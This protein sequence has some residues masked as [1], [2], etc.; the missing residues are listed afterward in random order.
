[1]SIFHKLETNNRVFFKWMPALFFTIILFV[2]P[3]MVFGQSRYVTTSG[4]NTTD[5]SDPS[6]PCLTI[7]YAMGQAIAGDHI[8]VAAGTYNENVQ[9][10]KS[11]QLLGTDA[12]VNGSTGHLGTFWISN[13]INDVTIDGFTLVGYDNANGS[14]EHAAL[15]IQG[16]N[17]NVTIT[18]NIITANGEAGLLT[19][20]ASSNNL[21][22]SGN[23]FN[24]QTFTG[25]HPGECGFST[26]F[27][28]P[29]TN[30]PRQLVVIQPGHTNLV[31][32]NNILSG[33][34]G[35]L[36]AG[37]P[38]P[39]DVI[40]QGNFLVT[41]DGTDS[42]ISGN[43]FNGQTSRFGSLLRVR[44]TGNS[45]F[46]NHF[47]AANLVGTAYFLYYSATALVGGVP[48]DA[49]GVL[50]SNTWSP[51]PTY[52][53]DLAGNTS[54]LFCDEPVL[55]ASLTIDGDTYASSTTGN[56]GNNEV[57]EIDVCSVSEEI[58]F[59]DFRDVS[60][61][62]FPD[63]K[64]YQIVEADNISAPFC[65]YCVGTFDVFNPYSATISLID[66]TQ[67]GTL[68]LK[69]FAF[70]D[71]H[72]LGVVDLDEC[73]GD[74]LIYII[75]L[76]PPLTGVA[77]EADP[78]GDVCLGATDVQYNAVVTGGN[79]SALEYLWTA[80]NNGTGAGAGF[81][82]FSDNSIQNPTR[83]WTA[84][85]GTKSVKVVVSSEG[86][87]DVE[88]LYVFEVTQD[89]E[90]PTLENT[91]H[92]TDEDVCVGTELWAEFDPGSGGAGDC[93]DEI[94]YSV[95]GG[96]TWNPYVSGNT[97]I[98]GSETVIIE[99]RRACDGLGCDGAGSVFAEMIR[100]N[101]LP[102]PVV[103][104]D[105]IDVDVCLNTDVNIVANISGGSAPY[106][107]TWTGTGEVYLN[108]VALL[109]PIFNSNVFGTYTL[110]INVTD[111]N[112]CSASD[113]IVINVR[114]VVSPTIVCPSDIRID[115]PIGECETVVNFEV[116][117]DD[118]CS[119]VVYHYVAGS[120]ESGDIFPIGV[121]EVSVYA[122]DVAG[123]ISETCSFTVT[124]VDYIN[125]NLGCKPINFSLD[126]DCTGELTP[127]EVLVGWETG[128]LPDL[129]CPGSFTIDVISP[130]GVSLGN[131]LDGEYIG[132]TL[133]YIITHVSGFRCWNTVLV[134]DKMSPTIACRDT[135]VHCLTDLTKFDLYTIFDNCGA[136]GVKI[137]EK[138]IDLPCDA[139]Y[140]SKVERTYKAVDNYGN[141]STPCTSTIY[142]LRPSRD[143]IVAPGTLVT[144]ECSE[145]YKKDGKGF[146]HPDVAGIPTFEGRELW[147]QSNLDMLYCNA[148]I[149][150]KERV[151][152]ESGC[153]TIIQRTWTIT[154]WHCSSVVELLVA[155]Q[156]LMI[157]DTT[158][159]AIP[160]QNDQVVTTKALSCS[161]LVQLPQL[162][163]TDNCNT[164]TKVL[165]NVITDGEPNG[166]V[167]GNGGSIEL[168]VGVHTITYSALDN[169]LNQ[170]EM[171]YTITVRDLTDPVAICDQFATVSLREDGQT[172]VTAQ[173]IN[174]GSF[175][176]CGDVT[177]QIRRLT[178]P[179]GLDQ[180][181][182]WY[183]RIDFCCA[184]A[185]QS[186]MVVLLVT[187]RGG[188]TNMCMVSVNVQDKI[189]P[190]I[191]CPED[192]TIR[193]CEFTFDPSLSGANHAFGEAVIT[194]NC[195]SNLD[196]L[197]EIQ[198]NRSQCGV[199]EVI[200][201]IGVAL[202]GKTIQTCQQ[203][204]TFYNDH[205]FYI[206]ES[207]I[208]DP[209]DGVIW[210]KDYTAL[211][212]CS[213]NGLAP[214][215]LPD[216]SSFPIITEGVCDMV[217]LRYDDQVIAFTQNGACYKI[218]RTWSIIDWCQ[219]NREW[220]YVQEIKVIDNDA[221]VFV[222]LPT[223]K[224]I[225]GT[226]TCES[227]E[228]TLDANAI[229]CTPAD[230]LVWTYK[231][232]KSGV[233]FQ[234]GNGN[235]VTDIFTVGEYSI[236]FTVSD[237][238][239]NLSQTSYEFEVI[240]TKPAVPICINGLSS[241]VTMM[242]TDGDGIGDTP[243]TMLTPELFDNKSY[244]PCGYD[245]VLSFSADVDDTLRTFTC[246]DL[247][248]QLIQLW[249]TDS[250]GN[251]AYCETTIDIQ[252]NDNLCS[253]M[254]KFWN[255]SSIFVTCS[256]GAFN[257][258]SQSYPN[259][260][261]MGVIDTRE[262]CQIDKLSDWG[263]SGKT[264]PELQYHGENDEWKSG[265]LGL[266]F[267]I[268]IDNIGNIFVGGSTVFGSIEYPD[269]LNPDGKRGS[270][271]I[272]K[273]DKESGAIDLNFISTRQS[274]N[275]DINFPN[276]MPNQ[277]MSGTWGSPLGESWSIKSGTGL[278]DLTFDK[279]N[280]SL[281]A[282]N[283][284]DG[285]IYKI[286]PSNGLITN[287][288]DPRFGDSDPSGLDNGDIGFAPK[289]QRPWGLGVNKEGDK[290]KLYYSLWNV[291]LRDDL[292]S[293][294]KYNQIWSVELDSNGNP[295][296][297]TEI[298][299]ITLPWLSGTIQRSMS[300]PV[301]D[302]AF[303]TRGEMLLAERGM[304]DD[305]GLPFPRSGVANPAHRARV[306]RYQKTG[307]TWTIF[308]SEDY[309]QVGSIGNIYSSSSG[310]IDFGSFG[311]DNL[312]SCDTLIWTTGDLFEV[313][314]VNLVYGALGMDYNNGTFS[315]HR[316]ID[317]DSN[318]S[319]N[320]KLG[321]GD[322]ESFNCPCQATE[323]LVSNVSG[324]IVSE[325][326][327]AIEEVGVEFVGVESDFTE[328][329]TDGSY[330]FGNV[331]NGKNY[332]IIPA[333]DDNHINGV[334]TFDLVL[335][336]RHI[337]DIE[338]I[339]SPYK[340][341]AA[342]VNNSRTITA[343]DLTELRKLVLGVIN[344]FPNNSSWRFIDANFRFKDATDPWAEYVPEFYEI[345]NLRNS[346]D[347]NFVGVKVGDV[348][349][350]AE[351]S[352]FDDAKVSS[353]ST[354][355]VAMDDRNV[356]KGELVKIPVIAS[357][358]GV[359]LGLQAQLQ[360]Q[361][362]IVQGINGASMKV[363]PADFALNNEE[364]VRIALATGQGVSIKAGQTLFVIEAEATQDGK[365]SEMISL[366]TAL[367]AEL[368]TEDNRAGQFDITW[369]KSD[370]DQASL[371]AVTPNPWNANAE[372]RFDLPKDGMVT[373]KV[374]DYAGKKV[375]NTIDH[376]SAGQNVIMLSRNDMP[377]SGLYFY[378]IRTENQVLAG[379]M[380]VIE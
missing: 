89:P 309:Y 336:Q 59:D 10:N 328:T 38:P 130:N 209:L 100:W 128:G 24:G 275:F 364:Q 294:T 356:V 337:L 291:D 146:P 158:P 178:D 189:A 274:T 120:L 129:G 371:A 286:D 171:S 61:S 148:I 228:V 380:I 345:T 37:M 88:A 287:V 134:E 278:G 145:D 330:A 153:K 263:P 240:T 202:D 361:G 369:R 45:V 122:E 327:K 318:L 273:I 170:G 315:N 244:H 323:P 292:V 142:L 155:V 150:Y 55:G 25:T 78:D 118:N 313:D 97:I 31:F 76:N 175:D 121:H 310:G 207:D 344:E 18:N 172:F 87:P 271:S 362:L 57:I 183:D 101:S 21:V 246:D 34:A 307:N 93:A 268:A 159:P 71:L 127:T 109:E 235:S 264:Y 11:V 43:T 92:G 154:E 56:D 350:D 188:N 48:D 85:T 349:N 299:E 156:T 176:A 333:K 167:T 181:E 230:E 232:F 284:E 33:T 248:E 16:I 74:T 6:L 51:N 40:G 185:N 366:G 180:D 90:A 133:D 266:V 54:V 223:A 239:G 138:I 112:N 288:Y 220:T 231:I 377:Q 168:G 357:N 65:T 29:T 247:G 358:S 125:P 139:L 36:D 116:E 12:I 124:I 161:A 30:V 346:M 72:D 216:S 311:C 135:A 86:C 224:L 66:N 353:R 32:T 334:S 115:L 50:S 27:D 227:R 62:A 13:G 285:N 215:T 79:T 84:T 370:T 67:Q 28:N 221:P 237:R 319:D 305:I 289:G 49:A 208:N 162:N 137:D 243:Q 99:G 238:C 131:H 341:F 229:D 107:H 351:V 217:G 173:A 376:Y 201:T 378:E 255:C 249:V 324:R 279:Y 81:N 94:R 374:K 368:Y 338:P 198:D 261:V 213:Y 256:P 14:I 236:E 26:Q 342:D 242:D 47:D 58:T 219:N 182:G 83:S 187:D 203:T 143:G 331:R 253:Q 3:G 17:N 2:L 95:D 110:G 306:L 44:G 70:T 212:Q 191:T 276:Q 199:G 205:P 283:F 252:D 102:L 259:D 149:E 218:L 326:N 281:F 314:G 96:A 60:G 347:V 375:I 373:F 64:V 119:G 204:I 321:V 343:S 320:T 222:D 103:I 339:T 113:E 152:G 69:F 117:A 304:I 312:N 22:V 360:T 141:E 111:E 177:L 166:S 192:L 316:L 329:N 300:N 23:E 257:T 98:M 363:T 190:R 245:F 260:F 41:I 52:T 282:S 20:Y 265:N 226:F 372:I 39:C 151:M 206:N 250:H 296:A 379:K 126:A 46:D 75:T 53:V 302:I 340:L 108:D 169:C 365:L 277:T 193:D 233:L 293:N 132:R 270:G 348:N 82:G 140:S 186:P 80:H 295:I 1:M 272:Y 8:Y 136:V 106:V 210:P 269:G 174:D 179:C 196:I 280:E 325:D 195:P 123:N 114:D 234:Q 298:L 147:P 262:T 19:E 160:Q 359:V 317:F 73:R 91:S 290:I 197:H 105:P 35:T 104:I 225:F 267:P 332:N 4:S 297:N 251:T 352:K 165:I 322:I 63:I 211:G 163:I 77:I 144:F 367:R 184:D 7:T 258:Q 15:Y 303:N 9:I 5:C 241:N 157:V 308:N 254:S 335:I 42:E 68:T 354:V 200:R 214:E 301:S 194:D 355:N 164:V